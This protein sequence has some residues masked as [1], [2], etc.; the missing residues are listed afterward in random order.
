MQITGQSSVPGLVSGWQIGIR[1]SVEA[2]QFRP[3][4]A[5]VELQLF[6]IGEQVDSSQNMVKATAGDG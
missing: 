2:I 5:V 4:S 6:H 3:A 1:L